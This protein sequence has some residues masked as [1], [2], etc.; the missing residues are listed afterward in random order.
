MTDR[1]PVE[2]ATLLSWPRM[3]DNFPAD[4]LRTLRQLVQ[5]LNDEHG[6]SDGNMI[7]ARPPDIPPG[8]VGGIALP[9]PVD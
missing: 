3:D 6:D 2:F 5:R 9:D 1:R 8:L 4:E 7:R